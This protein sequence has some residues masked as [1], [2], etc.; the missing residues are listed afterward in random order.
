M[1]TNGYDEALSLPTEE[2]ARVAVRTQ[3]IIA[4]ETGVTDTVDP[5]A[6]SYFV[7]TLTDQVEKAAWSYINKIDAMGGAVAAIE[8]GFMQ[9]EISSS[10]YKYQNAIESGE[11]VLIGVNRFQE[12]ED[13]ARELFSVDDSIRKVQVDK[14]VSLKAERNTSKVNEALAELERFANDGTNL[15]PAILSSVEAYA[16]LG[17]IADVLRKVFGEH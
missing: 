17:E 9:N 15:M 12:E 3:Q 16:T 8:E 11:E 6:G 4:Y 14:L 2:A 13:K 7:E 1:H 5:L 10:A